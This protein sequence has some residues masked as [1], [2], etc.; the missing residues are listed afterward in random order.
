MIVES[1]FDDNNSYNNDNSYNS[2]KIYEYTSSGIGQNSYLDRPNDKV[3]IILS[4]TDNTLEVSKQTEV[5]KIIVSGIS[6][7]INLCKN[8]YSTPEF[9]RSGVDVEINYIDC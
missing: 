2:K 6:N 5:T 4:G 3:I 1:F 7:T 9:I 8:V